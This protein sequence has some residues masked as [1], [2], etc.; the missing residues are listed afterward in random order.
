MARTQKVLKSFSPKFHQS[1]KSLWGNKRGRTKE[2]NNQW[3]PQDLD[4]LCSPYTKEIWIGEN[5]DLDLFS[6]FP[7]KDARFIGGRGS[8]AS[9]GRSTMGEKTSSKDGEPLGKKAP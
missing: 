3:K 7:Q 6:L 8:R 2:E 4:P 1:Y 5:V 9:F